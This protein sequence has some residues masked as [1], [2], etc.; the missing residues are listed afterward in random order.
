MDDSRSSLVGK[1]AMVISKRV[2]AKRLGDDSLDATLTLGSFLMRH[3][4]HHCTHRVLVDTAEDIRE[5]ELWF[6][7]AADRA[8][9]N[10]CSNDPISSWQ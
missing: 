1:A 5:L 9:D 10:Y 6:D 4:A 7:S 2:D 3:H 8:G